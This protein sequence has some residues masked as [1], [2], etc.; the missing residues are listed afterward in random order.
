MLC[1]AD[2][3][4]SDNQNAYFCYADVNCRLKVC[5]KDNQ[6][7]WFGTLDNLRDLLKRNC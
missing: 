4:V 1:N 5:W 6:E 3:L 2:E 7:D